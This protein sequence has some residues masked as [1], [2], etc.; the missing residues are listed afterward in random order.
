MDGLRDAMAKL[1]E[2]RDA[3]MIDDDLYSSKKC[4]LVDQ[5]IGSPAPT[6]AASSSVRYAPYGRSGRGAGRGVNPYGATMAL[7]P[8]AAYG[9]VVGFAMG[10]DQASPFTTPPEFCEANS[11]RLRGLPWAA[12]EADIY[13]FFQGFAITPGGV[14][15][16]IHNRG[17]FAGRGSGNAYVSFVSAQEAQRAIAQKNGHNIGSRYIE[18]LPSQNPNAGASVMSAYGGGVG[19]TGR[20]TAADLKADFAPPPD[21]M[22]PFCVR[23]RGLPFT[24]T[25]ADVSNFFAGFGLQAVHLAV[26]TIG[27]RAGQPTGNGFARFVSAG[28]ATRAQTMHGQYL[29]TRYIE[30]MPVSS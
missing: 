5:F 11:V 9:G 22:G 15:I 12:T 25:E 13:M 29:G 27:P 21:F 17:Q 6:S 3:G 24:A 4:A 7:A 10:G 2:L 28:E 16:T 30:I 8:S 14:R 26:H 1:D 23:M 19:P 20:T 18:V